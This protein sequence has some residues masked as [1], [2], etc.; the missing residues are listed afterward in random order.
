MTTADR[1]VADLMNALDCIRREAQDRANEGSLDYI[2]GLATQAVANCEYYRERNDDGYMVLKPKY[3]PACDREG[4]SAGRDIT[5]PEFHTCGGRGE[6]LLF[7]AGWTAGFEEALT[8]DTQPEVDRA[9]VKWLEFLSD[10]E[11]AERR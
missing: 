9:E 5:D 2:Y 7:M 10:T 1:V 8:D 11:T 4:A 3:C 6:K